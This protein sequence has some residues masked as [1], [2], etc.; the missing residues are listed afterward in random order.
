MSTNC[1]VEML[2]KNVI[3]IEAQKYIMYFREK[4][5]NEMIKLR[6]TSQNQVF[7]KAFNTVARLPFPKGSTLVKASLLH[8]EV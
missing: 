5:K 1:N 6:L 2:Y 8:S 3:R 4:S 7:Q